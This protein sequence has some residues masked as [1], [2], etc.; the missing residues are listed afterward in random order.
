MRNINPDCPNFIDKKDNHFK[1]LHR[2]MDSYFHNLHSNSIRRHMKHAKSLSKEDEQKIWQSG[3]METSTPR[4]LQNAAF[5][6]A[7]KMFL[8]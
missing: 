4:S 3:V 5:F 8:P 1:S 7:S 2:S 6:V